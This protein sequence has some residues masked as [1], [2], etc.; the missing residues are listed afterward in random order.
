MDT[1][2]TWGALLLGLAVIFGIVCVV[3]AWYR[4]LIRWMSRQAGRGFA[5][6]W[7]MVVDEREGRTLKRELY[8]GQRL[9]VVPAPAPVLPKPSPAGEQR[10]ED[11]RD[12]GHAWLGNIK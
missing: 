12:A 1:L 3:L 10:L 6:G 2:L 5:E 4:L 7:F 11:N 8:P 9:K